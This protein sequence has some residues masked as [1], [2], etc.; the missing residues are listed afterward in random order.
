[1][2]VDQVGPLDVVLNGPSPVADGT[3]N[4]MGALRKAM[5]TTGYKDLKEFQRIDVVVESSPPR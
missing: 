1:M 5:S 2:Q 4:I 3:A